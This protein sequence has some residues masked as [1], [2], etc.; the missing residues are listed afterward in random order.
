MKTLSRALL[1]AFLGLSMAL[2]F[3]ACC[4]GG[5]GLEKTPI[6]ED[7]QA[8]I[9]TWSGEEGSSLTINGDG[10][11]AVKVTKGVNKEITGGA[12]VFEGK[13]LKVELFGMEHTFTVDKAPEEGGDSMKLSGEKFKRL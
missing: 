7:K 10:S 13:S 9:G 11:G 4:G 1:V 3:Q 8:F 5:C 6:P 2:T 12:V